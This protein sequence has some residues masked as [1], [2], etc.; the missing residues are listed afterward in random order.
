[1]CGILVS[2]ALCL[3]TSSLDP[4]RPNTCSRPSRSCSTICFVIIDV[5]SLSPLASIRDSAKF[6][7]TMPRMSQMI[8]ISLMLTSWRSGFQVLVLVLGR[9]WFLTF[10][11][12][13][14]GENPK[15]SL[16]FPHAVSLCSLISSLVCFFVANLQFIIKPKFCS[17]GTTNDYIWILKLDV[18]SSGDQVQRMST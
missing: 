7:T 16:W 12:S 15:L 14:V 9:Y 6:L 18:C 2:S 10:G 3:A 11:F 5:S 8:F 17:L 4:P 13:L 1:M